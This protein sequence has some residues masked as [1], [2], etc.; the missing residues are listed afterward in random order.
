MPEEPL[1]PKWAEALLA[2]HP[3]AERPTPENPVPGWLKQE[4]RRMPL[5]YLIRGTEEPR[6][7][8][9]YYLIEDIKT[10][11]DLVVCGGPRDQQVGRRDDR[12]S[13]GR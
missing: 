10:Q 8:P 13:R 5:W 7:E 4:I 2:K 6:D 12:D 11:P 9:P 3:G 1:M